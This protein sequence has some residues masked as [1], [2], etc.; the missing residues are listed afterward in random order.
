MSTI[1]YGLGQGFAQGADSV[2][3]SIATA[4]RI[5]NN[6]EQLRIQNQYVQLAQ[7]KWGVQ[8][9]QEELAIREATMK[10]D[11]IENEMVANKASNFLI[12]GYE[13]GN[14]KQFQN[15]ALTN[16]KI[17][18]ILNTLG[19][20]NIE[21]LNDYTDNSIEAIAGNPE[22]ANQVRQNKNGYLVVTDSKGNKSLVD[23]MLLAG[24][25]GVQKYVNM[26]RIE[27]MNAIQQRIAEQAQT[28]GAK[29]QFNQ[30]KSNPSQFDSAASIELDLT[31]NPKQTS[32]KASV[33]DKKELLENTEFNLLNSIRYN[34]KDFDINKAKEDMISL[35]K[36]FTTSNNKQIR[37]GSASK[38]IDKALYEAE[39]AGLS[40]KEY[41]EAN[42]D[43]YLSS[44]INSYETTSGDVDKNLR[45]TMT[46]LD[47]WKSAQR[48]M[49]DS[50]NEVGLG[51]DTNLLGVLQ[52]AETIP[53]LD[54]VLTTA[55]S[56]LGSDV[57]KYLTA[58][59]SK[60]GKAAF[61]MLYNAMLKDM[62][63]SAVTANEFDRKLKELGMPG[64]TSITDVLVGMK[65]TLKAE[66]R[67]LS[68][69]KQKSPRNFSLYI[70]EGRLDKL[71]SYLEN[72][73][74]ML[75]K[76]PLNP[77]TQPTKAQVQAQA[78]EIETKDNNALLN[79]LYTAAGG[80]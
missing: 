26:N 21:G 56:K 23:T 42:K 57:G 1:A 66:I 51:T 47:S 72:V 10:L 52:K 35:Y 46:E 17:K 67:Y 39:L 64:E 68:D 50:L 65:N 45:K 48:A 40:L 20:V 78:V 49:I 54:K 14:Y 71:N 43:T 38:A 24:Q 60:E 31:I 62:S 36:L 61:L 2:A 80:K 55:S 58:I 70:G 18:G 16:Q 12:D 15:F 53:G 13:Y 34:E 8:K 33:F 22:L 29:E 77:T 19:I 74:N 63:G 27:R 75:K 76:K 11:A 32:G 9:Q 69:M 25:M 59:G 37:F 28:L 6:R 4:E 3:N 41:A 44:A 79:E 73:D 5:K 30:A 7:D